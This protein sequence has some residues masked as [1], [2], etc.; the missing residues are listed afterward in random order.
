MIG[1]TCSV[2]SGGQ[3]GGLDGLGWLGGWPGDVGEEWRC[4]ESEKRE[5]AQLGTSNEVKTKG[6]SNE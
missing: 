2:G 6:G 5:E 1:D 4:G 3:L